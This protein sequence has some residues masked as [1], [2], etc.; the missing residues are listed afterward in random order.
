MAAERIVTHVLDDCAAIGISM[1]FAQTFRRNAS[2]NG[3]R[4]NGL[5]DPFQAVS[6]MA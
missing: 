2:D 1:G 6:M 4:I 5:I 3:S